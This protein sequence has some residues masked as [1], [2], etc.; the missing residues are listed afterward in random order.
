[1]FMP[2]KLSDDFDLLQESQDGLQHYITAC[3]WEISPKFF[4]FLSVQV[5]IGFTSEEITGFDIEQNNNQ[6]LTNV[7][8]LQV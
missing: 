3:S 8:H 7:G 6:I 1:M 4:V 5:R 2:L